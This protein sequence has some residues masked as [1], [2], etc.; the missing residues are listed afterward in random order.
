MA[1]L[2]NILVVVTI[3]LYLLGRLC[4]DMGWYSWDGISTDGLEAIALGALATS[5]ILTIARRSV[6]G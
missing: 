5:A 3:A 2:H 1:V 6:E 4:D